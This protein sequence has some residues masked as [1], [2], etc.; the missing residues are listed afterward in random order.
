MKMTI[1]M[2]QE[3]HDKLEEMYQT[4]SK[5]PYLSNYGKTTEDLTKHIV[6]AEFDIEYRTLDLIFKNK[7]LLSLNK[8][9]IIL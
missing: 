5:T 2:Y 4:I 3:M 9:K 7:S 1:K 6:E 8:T